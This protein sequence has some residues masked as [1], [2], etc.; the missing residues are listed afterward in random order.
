MSQTTPQIPNLCHQ[1]ELPKKTPFPV[2]TETDS[3]KS[4]LKTKFM[5]LF[6]MITVEPMLCFYV[7]PQMLS[8]IAVNVLTFQMA[9]RVNLNFN[10]TICDDLLSLNNSAYEM[11]VQKEAAKLMVWKKPLATLVPAI[12]ILFMGSYSDRYHIR[13]PFLLTP[14]FGEVLLSISYLLC[15]AYKSLLPMEVLAGSE[16]FF[17]AITGGLTT[18]KIAVYSYV[19]DVSSTDMRT[20]RLG[21]VQIL[22]AI[23]TPI[24]FAL[25]GILFRA[26]SFYGVFSIR[27][28]VFALGIL[29]GAFRLKESKAVNV[30]RTKSFCVDFF[31]L[32]NV[33][34]TFK[35]LVRKRDDRKRTKL[36]LMLISFIIVKGVNAAEMDILFLYTRLKFQWDEMQFGFF[37]TYDIVLRLIG[38]VALYFSGFK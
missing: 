5:G 22:S 16:A 4:S 2:N 31:D 33:K 29:Y 13:K 8:S 30:V 32:K 14:L 20:T 17:T 11:Q 35:V 10:E 1:L 6:N 36:F 34:D 9:C 27:T 12:L 23:M 15:T 21:I 18:V 25:S 24:A 26:T 28:C 19:A 37:T 3:K 38:K 7:F